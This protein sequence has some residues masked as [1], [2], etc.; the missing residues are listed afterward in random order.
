MLETIEERVKLIKMGIDGKKIERLYI[1][2]NNLKVIKTPILYDT[3][4]N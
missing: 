4:K 2:L 1:E 3:I